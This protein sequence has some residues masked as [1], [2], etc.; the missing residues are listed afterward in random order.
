MYCTCMYMYSVCITYT[1]P[2]VGSTCTCI[3]TYMYVHC[4]YIQCT[5]MYMYYVLTY[6][7]TSCLIG[8]CTYMYMYVFIY[9]VRCLRPRSTWGRVQIHTCIYYRHRHDVL[10][11]SKLCHLT[12]GLLCTYV[13]V[14]VELH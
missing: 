5:Y 10:Y 8:T 11:V 9:Q 2:M 13:H 4:V 6:V 12:G 1:A 3:Y 7:C 14:C